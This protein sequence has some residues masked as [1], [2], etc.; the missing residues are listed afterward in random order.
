MQVACVVP[1]YPP[2]SRV[3]AWL[4]THAYLSHLASQGW[5]VD[6]YRY[7]T[8]GDRYAIDGVTVQDLPKRISADVF[9]GHLGDNGTAAKYAKGRP[10][11]QFVHGWVDHHVER[12]VGGV[13]VANS[14]ATAR[15]IDRPCVVC[16][17]ITDPTVHAASPGDAVTLVN[18]AEVKGGRLFHLLTQSMPDTR[19]IGV[20]GGWGRQFIRR[21]ANVTISPPVE[22]MRTVWSQTRILLMPSEREAWGM[23][24]VEAMC[25]GIPVIAH[26]TDG[27]VESLGDAGIF[28]DRRDLAGWRAAIEQLGDPTEWAAA[29]A[30]AKHRAAVL[31]SDTQARLARF[32][33]AVEQLVAVKA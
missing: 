19:F 24:G 12:L 16:E 11:V 20:R 15:W 13:V 9:V 27:L 29:S 25:S 26:P 1:L 17:P 14:H 33:D 3:G 4:A 31:A 2:T 5:Q 22:D 32:I 28:V 21:A 7:L 10:L 23:A 6:V 8:R 30:K 18:L